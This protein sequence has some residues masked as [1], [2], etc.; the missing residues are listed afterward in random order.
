[1]NDAR[2][3]VWSYLGQCSSFDPSQL[4]VFLVQDD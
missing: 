1:M 4:Q 2:N 3:L